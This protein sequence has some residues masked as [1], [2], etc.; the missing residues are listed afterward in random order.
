[1]A[2]LYRVSTKQFFLNGYYRFSAKYSGRPGY[3]DNSDNQ[4]VKSKGPIPKGSYTIGR[5][6]HHPKTGRWTLRLTPLPSNQM[7]GRSGFMIHGDSQAHPG[8][9]SDGCI[10]LDFAFREI[11]TRSGITLLEVE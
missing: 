9:A 10:I 7:C 4:C 8:Q 5:P 3:Q 11:I 2:W 1:M 6:F